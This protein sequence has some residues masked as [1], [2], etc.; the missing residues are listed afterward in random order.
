MEVSLFWLFPVTSSTCRY[1]SRI[2]FQSRRDRNPLRTT[3]FWMEW[4]T[5]D[6]AM[7]GSP[8][9]TYI[10]MARLTSTE[11]ISTHFTSSSRWVGW[12]IKSNLERMVFLNSKAYSGE[13]AWEPVEKVDI[14]IMCELTQ[15]L[16]VFQESCPQTVDKIGKREELM[17]NPIKTSDI[18]WNFEKFLID[19][20]GRPR[21][22]FHPTA[23]SHG[24]VVQPFIDQ[25]MNEAA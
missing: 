1:L 12:V 3:N 10:F 18:T 5:C 7:A 11:T 23:W 25:L 15:Q 16:R 9:K 13:I 8:I 19:R 14:T 17:Y 21:F 4:C 22:R 20:K 2:Y 6:Q 24:D